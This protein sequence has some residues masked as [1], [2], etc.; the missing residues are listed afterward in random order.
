[1]IDK[2]ALLIKKQELEERLE[3]IK[4]DIGNKLNADSEEQATEL[5]NRDVILEIARVTEEEL[6]TIN[7]KLNETNK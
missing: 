2:D 3:K 7:A 5:E 1:M 6:A 4:R